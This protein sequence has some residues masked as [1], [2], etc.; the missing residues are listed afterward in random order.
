M[1]L[2]RSRS[3]EQ[4]RGYSHSCGGRACP[5]TRFQGSLLAIQSCVASPAGRSRGHCTDGR[6]RSCRYQPRA[7]QPAP[8]DGCHRSCR[9]GR[10]TEFSNNKNILT[11]GPI[12]FKNNTQ[13]K[14]YTKMPFWNYFYK[15]GTIFILKIRKPFYDG[16]FQKKPRFRLILWN[17]E[18]FL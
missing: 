11:T 3:P 6:T 17:L 13:R 18:L 16:R 15:F 5:R 4:C 12:F 7:I 14:M 2:N 8:R 1:R 9:I 10:E